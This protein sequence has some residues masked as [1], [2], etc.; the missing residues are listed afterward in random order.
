MEHNHP[1]HHNHEHHHAPANFDRAFAVGV[2]LNVGFVVTEAIFGTL[3]NSLALVA[4]A[5]HNLSD[6]LGLL[7]AWG[8]S[9]LAR[10]LPTQRRTYG[11]R[12]SSILATLLNALVLLIAVGGIAW[13][14]IL[15]FSHPESVASEIVI[16]VAGAG[17]LVNGFTAWLFMSG[18]KHDINIRGAY[19]HMAADA[20]VSFGVVVAAIVMCYTGWLWLDPVVSLVIVL[21]IIVGTW[22]LLRES[23]NLALDAVPERV[24]PA[25]VE[26]FLAGL[27]GV[28]AVHDLHIWGMSTTEIALT[29]HL[30]KPDATIDDA[31][32][33]HINE[34]LH[35]RFGIG[36]TTV[37]FELGDESHPCRQAPMEA[38]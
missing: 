29:V 26:A 38:V 3:A 36:H 9:V 2:V 15:R 37:Q 33:S 7:L 16:A 27:P 1:H 11:L 18:Q 22:G 35:H 8:A 17:I 10:R 30:V 21:V 34:E 28:E 4:D 12:R 32:L 20:A 6:V 19:L 14:A 13:E 31:L 25:E 24:H 23:L 5:G